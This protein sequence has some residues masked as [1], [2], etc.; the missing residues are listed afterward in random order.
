MVVVS[1]EMARELPRTIRSLSLSMQQDIGHADYEVL[2]VDNGSRAKPDEEVLAGLGVS[3][4]VLHVENPNRSPARAVN[5]GLAEARGKLVGVFVDG[6]RLASPGLLAG[7]LRASKLHHRAV[8]A[9]MGFHLGRESQSLAVRKGYGVEAED[10]LLRASRWEEDGY[11]LFEVGVFSDSCRGGFFS[12]MYE[13]SALFMSKEMWSELR[14]FDER[15]VSRGGGLVN[16]DAY[17]RACELPDVELVV[18]L[19]EAT[20]HQY[21]GG[22]ATNSEESS[23]K[24]FHAEYRVIRGRR[25]E[26]PA[27]TPIFVG[28]VRR[29]VLPS[30]ALSVAAPEAARWGALPFA[31]WAR[32]LT[33]PSAWVQYLRR[34]LPAALRRGHRNGDEQARPYE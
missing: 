31:V 34:R 9:S 17:R 21:H 26:P 29:A 12:P 16:L 25:F 5:L 4:R 6:A 15:F 1:F 23:W 30:I 19:G 24:E 7:A 8:I 22:V 10:R 28:R 14:G 2:V 13:S 20:F 27:A 32:L 11:R 18:L 3:A 33:N